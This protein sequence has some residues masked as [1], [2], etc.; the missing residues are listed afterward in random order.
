MFSYY[1]L[2]CSLTDEQAHDQP[3]EQG[4]VKEYVRKNG[5]RR[6]SRL[7]G[8][9]GKARNMNALKRQA[10]LTNVFSYCLLMCSSSY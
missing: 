9:M 2:M 6:W 8:R 4:G 7:L 3:D 1:L 10:L 5:I